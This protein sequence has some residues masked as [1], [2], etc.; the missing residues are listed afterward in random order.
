MRLVLRFAILA[1]ALLALAPALPAQQRQLAKRRE[2]L[3]IGLG[4]GYGTADVSC[5]S[6]CVN[7]DRAG[8][9]G[10]SFRIGGTLQPTLLLGADLAFWTHK[11]GGIR[12]YILNGSA[13][14]SHYPLRRSNFFVKGGAGFSVYQSRGLGN[15]VKGAG[16]GVIGGVGY[17]VR[18]SSNLFITPYG[19]LYLGWPGE[20]R[21]QGVL[22]SRG[23][24]QNVADVG[25]A[26]MY[27]TF[28]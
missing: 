6:G 23:W 14:V 15:E 1:T 11:A 20:L 7:S 26:V 12:D 19:N 28:E 25:V 10:A 17:D 24:K 8:G 22:V 9:L 3:W 13:T 16:L 18:I 5:D 2:G 21:N 27:Y 4:G